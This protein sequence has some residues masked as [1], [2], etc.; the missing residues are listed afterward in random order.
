MSSSE[1]SSP[2]TGT[3]RCL[4]RRD[5]APHRRG[6]GGH[7]RA[8]RLGYC[9][10]SA[11]SRR[12]RVSLVRLHEA[13]TEEAEAAVRWY[14]ERVARLGN[15]FRVELLGS[16]AR[17]VRAPLLWPPSAYD[18]RARRYLLPRFPYGVEPD[19]SIVVARSLRSPTTP[20]RKRYFVMQRLRPG[21]LARSNRM[22]F[23]SHE[24]ARESTPLHRTPDMPRHST[25]T[26]STDSVGREAQAAERAA[27]MAKPE[28]LAGSSRRL[29]RSLRP[30]HPEPSINVTTQRLPAS[31]FPS[32]F[33]GA[34]GF[35]YF[36]T[37]P[38]PCLWGCGLS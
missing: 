18:R 35:H 33:H 16:V 17:I 19:A 13:A 24:P 21:L 25:G 26:L 38:K 6:G 11:R 4:D 1:A 36:R 34:L 15:A 23:G 22:V 9:S 29:P 7:S 3:S 2:M 32:G 20:P 14:N 28:V 8:A 12:P 10:G 5:P 27:R 30:G 37:A 31:P